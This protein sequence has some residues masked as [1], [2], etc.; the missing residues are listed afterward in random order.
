M[1]SLVSS[2]ERSTCQRSRSRTEEAAV[3]DN[4]DLAASSGIHVERIHGSTAFLSS[5]IAG[6]SG[7]LLAAILPVN[8]YLGLSLLLPAFAVIVLGTVGSVPGVIIGALIVGLLRAFSE[9]VLTGA[10]IALD[11]PTASG[12]AQVMPFIFLVG[13]LLL[14]PRGIGSAVQRWNIERIRKRR[15]VQQSSGFPFMPPIIKMGNL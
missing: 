9:P 2:M 7:A 10:G 3:A 5:A 6:F 15:L 1:R 11:R 14:A 8:P 13:L 4:P 12:F